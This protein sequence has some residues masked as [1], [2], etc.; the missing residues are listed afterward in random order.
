MSQH[1][2]DRMKQLVPIFLL[3]NFVVCIITKVISILVYRAFGPVLIAYLIVFHYL[4]CEKQWAL[5]C[6]HALSIVSIGAAILLSLQMINKVVHPE[7]ILPPNYLLG[8][9]YVA[10]AVIHLITSLFLYL[11]HK[12]VR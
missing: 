7:T 3:I 2:H 1:R 4:R 10:L 9:C 6:Y 5:W 11:T 12:K 8:F